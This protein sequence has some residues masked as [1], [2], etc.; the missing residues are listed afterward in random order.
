MV[1]VSHYNHFPSIE[2]KQSV[3]LP[4]TAFVDGQMLML[5]LKK[6]KKRAKKSYFLIFRYEKAYFRGKKAE[7]QREL[8]SELGC[9]FL[10]AQE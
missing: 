9:G 7:K 1:A 2:Q 4:N 6:L 10:P 8:I 3:F 5:K